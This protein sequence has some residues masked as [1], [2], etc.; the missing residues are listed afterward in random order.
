MD[1]KLEA[2][3]AKQREIVAARSLGART[4]PDLPLPPYHVHGV[5]MLY[6][7]CRFDV[8]A[9]ARIVP[10]GLTPSGSGW[11]VIGLYSAEQGWGIAPFTAFFMAA[12]LAG[13]DSV[14]GSPGNYMH[15]G[16][17]SDMGGRVMTGQ[18]NSNF[19]TG[20]SR[21][22]V[23]D[24]VVIG[25][26][27]IGDRTLVRMRA[28][29]GQSPPQV[30]NG[31]SRY[32]GRQPGGTGFTSYSV[33]FTLES[34]DTSG[35][36]VEFLDGAREGLNILEPLEYVWPIYASPMD[37]AFTPPRP[38]LEEGEPAGEDAQG[39]SLV[40]VFSQMGRAAAILDVDGKLLTMNKQ[41][42]GLVAEGRIGVAGQQ[43]RL[44]RPAEDAA[45]AAMLLEVRQRGLGAVSER[46]ALH[47]EAS[48]P[49]LIAQAIALDP[50]IGGPGSVLVFFDDPARASG[51]D[52]A[53]ALRLLGLTAAEARIAGLV[54]SGRAPR[55]VAD[56]LQLTLNTVRSALKITFDKLGISRQSELAKI[57]ARLAG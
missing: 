3:R 16:L 43:L 44:S 18:Y 26:A 34:R 20:W 42:N 52:S 9:V 28:R 23:I 7:M 41:A 15:S 40:G 2:R 32:V 49:P 6:L 50:S 37:M 29:V 35:Q 54:G 4:Q 14:D 24:G 51:T 13:A 57:V 31:V 39:V 1:D 5:S 17:F 10:P 11:G 53:A 22:Q 21:H 46:H 36:A 38:F 25:E 45:L 30:L 19:R 33:A 8:D 56:E 48:G 12:E 47:P 55:D 27:G